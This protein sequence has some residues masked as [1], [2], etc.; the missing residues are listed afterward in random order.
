MFNYYVRTQK[1]SSNTLTELRP[2]LPWLLDVII[3]LQKCYL[4]ELIR[5][6]LPLAEWYGLDFDLSSDREL[7]QALR[8]RLTLGWTIFFHFALFLGK[9]GF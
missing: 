1:R 4:C 8:L 7:S 5:C 9:Q 3:L 6:Y 2:W